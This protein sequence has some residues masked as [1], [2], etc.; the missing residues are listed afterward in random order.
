[1][2]I[3]LGLLSALFYGSADFCGGLATKRSSMWSVVVVSQAVGFVLLFAVLPFVPGH[4]T[5]VDYLWGAAAGVCGGLGLALLY[6]ALSV[7]K[8]GIVSPITAVL[9]AS[10]PVFAGVFHG[11]ALSHYQV[12][13][14]VMALLAVI[15]ISTSHEET[16]EIEIRTAGVKEAIASGIVLGGFYLLLAK[17]GT[18]AGLYPLVAARISSIVFLVG[19][20]LV[21]RQPLKPTR[22]ALPLMV[23]AG[24]IDMVANALY[25]L[26]TFNGYLS[27]AAVL[28]S[29]YPAS[30]VLLAWV[31]LKERLARVQYAGLLC[32]LA[33]VLLIAA[34]R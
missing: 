9:A 32:A 6:H 14:I 29:L 26:A 21:G 33:G 31:V 15:L 5:A 4:A 2:G 7:G 34:K 28:T 1:M 30:T 16:G 20:A 22:S 10:L 27:I 13:G 11:E 23:A 25:V 8:M 24:A 19:V 17:S 18:Q 12:A 3:L